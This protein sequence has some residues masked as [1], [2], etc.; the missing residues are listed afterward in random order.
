[1]K[2]PVEIQNHGR[3]TAFLVSAETFHA[4]WQCYR[5]AMFVG[6][7]SDEDLRG[8]AEARVPDDL[9]WDPEEPQNTDTETAPG[10]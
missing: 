9:D 1:M 7:L 3:T 6:E 8:I 2:E 5:K 4:M 10:R